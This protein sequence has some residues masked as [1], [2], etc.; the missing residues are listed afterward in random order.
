M[1]QCA[2]VLVRVPELEVGCAR[3]REVGAAEEGRRTSILFTQSCVI[4]WILLLLAPGGLSVFSEMSCESRSV[5]MVDAMAV[6]TIYGVARSRS[7]LR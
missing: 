6:Y 5:M 1:C 2:G 3:L 7:R 4:D